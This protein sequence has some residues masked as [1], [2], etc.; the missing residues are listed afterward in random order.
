VDAGSTFSLPLVFPVAE[1]ADVEAIEGPAASSQEHPPSVATEPVSAAGIGV[2]TQAAN[3]PSSND[4]QTSAPTENHSASELA[5]VFSSGN[6]VLVVEDN[7]V[8]QMVVSA[9]LEQLGVTVF[10]ADDGQEGV[11]EFMRLE[12]NLVF[13]DLSMPLVDGLESTSMI[14]RYEKTQGKP[15]IPIVALTANVMPVL[16]LRTKSVAY[17]RVWTTFYPS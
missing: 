6:K 16:C 11:D 17:K 2:D 15:P 5:A 8:N 10:L 9:M 7:P 14:R 1:S 4:P 13:M 3:A 12:P